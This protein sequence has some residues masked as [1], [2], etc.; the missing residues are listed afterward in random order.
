[1]SDA[2]EE[3][4]PDTG[5]IDDEAEEEARQPPGRGRDLLGR[6]GSPIRKHL[7][8][9]FGHVLKG[10]EDQ[11]ERSN[12]SDEWWAIYHC[13]LGGEQTF[14]GTA[15]IYVPAIRDAVNARVTRFSNQLFPTTG[16]HIDCI[17]TDG[18]Q[19]MEVIA[20]AN[21][22]I[23]AAQFETSVVRPLLQNGDIEGQYNLYIGSQT[24][25]RQIVSRETHAPRDPLTGAEGEGETIDDIR[26]DDIT[27]FQPS[28]EVLH[29]SDV[30]VLPVAADSVEQALQAGGSVT[31][32]R[33][34]SSEK[35]ERMEEAGEIRSD[36]AEALEV[37]MVSESGAPGLTDIGRQLVKA[38]GIRGK[39]HHAMVFETWLML[40]LNEGGQ[41]AKDG[42]RRLCRVWFGLNREQLGA[43]RNP[44]WNDRC[45]LLSAPV[46]KVAGVL[47]GKSLVEPVAPVQYEANDAANERADVDHMGAMPIIR[48][49]PGHGNSPLVLA[50]A[51]V[52]DAAP[53]DISFMEFPD[54]APRAKAR[55]LDAY[56]IIFQSLSVNP[57][58]LPQQAPLSGKGSQARIAQEQQVDLLTTASSVK[59]LIEAILNPAVAWIIDL[60][61]QFRDADLTVRAYGELGIKAEMI[62]VPPLQNRARYSFSWIGAQQSAQN[63][64]LIQ[65][66]TQ[67]I[68]VAKEMEQQLLREGIQLKV[69]PAMERQSVALFGAKTAAITFVDARRN[70]T[71]PAD[72]ENALLAEGHDP[73]V[74]PLD[75]DAEHLRKH[76]ALAQESGD[77]FGN[78]RVHIENHI[79]QLTAKNQAMVAAQ[80]PGA[81]GVPGGAGP[82]VS[83]RA[84]GQGP[85]RPGANPAQGRPAQ[86]PAG[87]IHADRL[88]AGG[89]VLQ[90][91]RKM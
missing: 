27:E 74:H 12:D 18:S 34:W 58:M 29:D 22:Y 6:A 90:M 19:P 30:L 13:E 77:P 1:M 35:I 42:K 80:Q 49:V 43:R 68:N 24:F 75:S 16:H 20:L 10:F 11:A 38:V 82:G 65:G 36:M 48:R 91:P 26:E 56:Q 32:L 62:P 44:Y 86:Q 7:D 40:P 72:E 28:F 88:P 4:P 31:I 54:L 55:I 66:G 51:A 37:G 53:G 61:H 71:V 79:Q 47:K 15:Q 8:K 21:H 70:L 52:W 46:N 3:L 33:R 73:P 45:P 89:G 78:I 69:A 81:M 2:R 85:P 76:M 5:P 83:G 64:A 57:S 59:V 23:G 60:D 39:G 9:V 63:M 87:A 17:S 25:E 67:F 84:R 41:Y 14:N 50:P